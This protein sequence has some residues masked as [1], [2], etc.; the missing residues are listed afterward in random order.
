MV[1]I[2]KGEKKKKAPGETNSLSVPHSL[3]PFLAYQHKVHLLQEVEILPTL[4]ELF[5]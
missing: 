5:P 4:I 3:T 2:Q 1:I